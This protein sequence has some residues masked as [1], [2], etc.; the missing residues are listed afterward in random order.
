MAIETALL[1]LMVIVL[2]TFALAGLCN[3]D[4]HDKGGL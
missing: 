4:W 3:V 1:W 2:I